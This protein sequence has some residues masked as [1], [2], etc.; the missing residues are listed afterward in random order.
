MATGLAS[1]GYPGNTMAFRINPNAVDWNF[2]I[3]TSVIDTLGGRVVQIIGSQLSDIV[4]RGS[5][6]EK[7]SVGRVQDTSDD[8]PGRSWRLMEAFVA[9]MRE[10]ADY[11]TT[12]PMG[13]GQPYD[14]SKTNPPLRFVFPE[15]DWDFSVYIKEI[16]DPNG[17]SI[18]HSSG[19]F[20][21]EYALTLFPVAE[22]AA[23][24]AIL[25]GKAEEAA[26]SFLDRISAGIG[27]D[28]DSHRYSG[29]TIAEAQEA[30]A[31]KGPFPYSA[32]EPVET[33]PEA[34]PTPSPTPSPDDPKPSPPPSSGPAPT[35][36]PRPQ[37][38]PQPKST[39]A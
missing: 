33:P 13:N 24:L 37:P 25:R 22:N 29:R 8:G 5:I 38:A 39:S 9:K 19:R 12:T 36:A 17:G 11:Q 21:Y 27:W 31:G 28:K 15:F 14:I 30:L 10:F 1:I 35:P 2:D 34:A 23:T 7:R 26:Q 32:D 18:T 16:S 4:V 3:F 20:S 6:G